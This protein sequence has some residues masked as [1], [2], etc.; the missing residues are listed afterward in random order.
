MLKIQSQQHLE[1]RGQAIG[2]ASLRYLTESDEVHVQ[3]HF[4][5]GQYTYC[6]NLMSNYR[7]KET[8][9]IYRVIKV[10]LIIIDII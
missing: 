9:D 2:T 6:G 7:T 4:P 8:K 1:E 5:Q 10:L 3:R